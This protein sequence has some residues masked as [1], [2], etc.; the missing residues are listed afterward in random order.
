[1]AVAAIADAK[2][3][4]AAPKAVSLSGLEFGRTGNEWRCRATIDV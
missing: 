4:G 2:L 3:I 1:M